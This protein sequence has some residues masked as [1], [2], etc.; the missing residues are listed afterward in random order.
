MILLD[1]GKCVAVRIFRHRQIQ[2]VHREL[3]EPE[4]FV[5][6]VGNGFF[7]SAGNFPALGHR[8]MLRRGSGNREQ[9]RHPGAV[10]LHV[11]STICLCY[12]YNRNKFPRICLTEALWFIDGDIVGKAKINRVVR[13]QCFLR[14]RVCLDK[15]SDSEMHRQRKKK[16]EIAGNTEI[17]KVFHVKIEGIRAP[18]IHHLK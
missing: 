12:V 13:K 17:L 3:R 18:V 9:I 14:E 6:R 2:A 11:P 4:A 5:C 7:L 15:V 16:K 1:I 8:A 10:E